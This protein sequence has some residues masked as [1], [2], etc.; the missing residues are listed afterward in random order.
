MGIGHQQRMSGSADRTG[1]H[2]LQRTRSWSSHAGV[3]LGCNAKQ[4]GPKDLVRDR[5]K[6]LRSFSH[7]DHGS[8]S[9]LGPGEGTLSFFTPE[10]L[11]RSVD[12]W[13]F[14][15]VEANAVPGRGADE[16]EQLVGREIMVDTL[17]VGLV[18]D[19]HDLTDFNETEKHRNRKHAVWGSPHLIR[20]YESGMDAHG[21]E[22]TVKLWKA[23]EIKELNEHAKHGHDELQAHRHEFSPSHRAYMVKCD[24]VATL[25]TQ[26]DDQGLHFSDGSKTVDDEVDRVFNIVDKD[27]S[28]A[29]SFQ[30]FAGWLTRRQMATQGF[31]TPGNLKEWQVSWT[32][33]DADGSH[34]LCRDEFKKVMEDIADK[35]W[36]EAIDPKTKRHYYYH[37]LTLET[38]WV[39]PSHDKEIND[40]LVRNGVKQQVEKNK[41]S[42]PMLTIN[43]QNMIKTLRVQPDRYRGRRN[44]RFFLVYC[45]LLIAWWT[46][47]ADI[48]DGRGVETGLHSR[49]SAIQF[50]VTP[51]PHF[52]QSIRATNWAG[53]RNLGDLYDLTLAMVENLYSDDDSTYFTPEDRVELKLKALQ[54]VYRNLEF[55][56]LW[57]AV[58]V[59]TDQGNVRQ[60]CSNWVI[61]DPSD[62][63][64]A[65]ECEFFERCSG[66]LL[67]HAQ[68][69]VAL[70]GQHEA[71]TFATRELKCRE[72]RCAHRY[73][74]VYD[75][76]GVIE[77]AQGLELSECSNTACK[78][79]LRLNNL[80][81]A[82]CEEWMAV[83]HSA[84]THD[85][86][87]DCLSQTAATHEECGAIDT[88]AVSGVHLKLACE[89]RAGCKYWTELWRESCVTTAT[90]NSWK[91]HGAS[92]QRPSTDA[93]SGLTNLHN[94]PLPWLML[95]MNR[96]KFHSCVVTD[97]AD[98]I[99][100]G[101]FTNEVDKTEFIG[102][103][104]G[105]VYRY[106]KKIGGFPF[107]IRLD[108]TVPQTWIGL[109]ELLRADH[110]LSSHTQDFTIECL[111]INRNTQTLGHWSIT[112]GI[113]L[114][115]MIKTERGLVVHSFPLDVV[116]PAQRESIV[117]HLAIWVFFSL[118]ID[119]FMQ[120]RQVIFI[121]SKEMGRGFIQ[122][123]IK[124]GT[125][126]SVIPPTQQAVLASCHSVGCLL[127]LLLTG[128]FIR[129]ELG[130][131]DQGFLS[132]D[133]LVKSG[134]D[135]DRITQ[136]LVGYRFTGV[137]SDTDVE[138]ATRCQPAGAIGAECEIGEKIQLVNSL[139]VGLE[140]WV[141]YRSVWSLF[142][143]YNLLRLLGKI[144]YQTNYAVLLVTIKI[145][146]R[147][148][149][150]F[151][152]LVL[153]SGALLCYAFHLCYGRRFFAFR[154]MESTMFAIMGPILGGDSSLEAAVM[155]SSRTGD[156]FLSVAI[157][158]IYAC[159]L[160]VLLYNVFIAIIV[161]GYEDAKDF[162]DN[163][164]N[165]EAEV[166]EY[167][168]VNELLDV[169]ETYQVPVP[170]SK[171][172]VLYV[173]VLGAKVFSCGNQP[174]KFEEA[175]ALRG[176]DFEVSIVQPWHGAVVGL[177]RVPAH[178]WLLY[179]FSI[180][181]IAIAWQLLA[182][183]C[184]TVFARRRTFES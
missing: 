26:A 127:M 153:A 53:V 20:F 29:I 95:K 78:V 112:Y 119:L 126:F 22:R 143:V 177:S 101:K 168:K 27:G 43:V 171:K 97:D 14:P 130:D 31:V 71:D 94:H 120:L 6:S 144:Y 79:K 106:D 25:D 148:L 113:D 160:I 67:Q 90:Y 109:L 121:I 147:Q 167:H 23:S 18:T 93:N 89:A 158:W 24:A 129:G 159:Y 136:D 161:D 77:S 165:I 117:H 11:K 169:I 172:N 96:R 38:K 156:N 91:K 19:F 140:S 74:M 180:L 88:P 110:W 84:F 45:F 76:C 92:R 50:E 47:I 163:R 105:A 131:L 10:E 181:F 80:R 58:K 154:T 114:A 164:R 12:E 13:R 133:W 139:S 99:G 63:G 56:Q 46:I 179:I 9:G 81:G 16:G 65:G 42:G 52:S 98:C 116:S 49:I 151:L 137:I 17:G 51:G 33:F 175:Q 135:P 108:D 103:E 62:G 37:K 128:K 2:R 36:G 41:D 100:V 30:E 173:K 150:S 69:I 86:I 4:S 152:R 132:T 166:Q 162:D 73:N 141:M 184:S 176:Y 60:N 8:I 61:T 1:P 107:Y 83:H 82:D 146:R 115:G 68:Q 57:D 3:A 183:A 124:A 40:F 134:T 54:N 142:C 138:D 15:E 145:A 155:E 48:G 182:G 72:Q 75:T 70:R 55:T 66:E 157:Y 118:M 111:T 102:H 149:G 7:T 104:T 39:K 123:Q 32:K 174:F 178:C 44:F 5:R 125:Q 170:E 28:G 35:D 64:F 87:S 122:L 85:L 21:V 59:D 34:T